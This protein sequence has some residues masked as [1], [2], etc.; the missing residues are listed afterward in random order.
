MPGIFF[1]VERPAEIMI[2]YTDLDGAEQTYHA[3]DFAALCCQHEID[4]LD[5]IRHI[6]HLSPLR[7]AMVLKQ[8]EKAKKAHRLNVRRAI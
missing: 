2:R 5:G 4:H 8:F 6:D 1:E 7:R 3:K